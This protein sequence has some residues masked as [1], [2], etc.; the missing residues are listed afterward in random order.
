MPHSPHTFHFT[1]PTCYITLPLQI[2]L[3]PCSH[4]LL[5]KSG[6][7]AVAAGPGFRPVQ[8]ATMTSGV[9]VLDAEDLEILFPVGEFLLKRRRAEAGLDPADGSVIQPMGMLHVVQVFIAGDRATP[10]FPPP[11]RTKK[12]LL[13]LRPHSGLDEI[14]H[15]KKLFHRCS[16]LV[17]EKRCGFVEKPSPTRWLRLATQQAR[18]DAQ[19]PSRLAAQRAMAAAAPAVPKG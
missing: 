13:L 11:Y 7:I 8:I 4:L 9:G 10:Q 5:E 17:M 16:D 2:P 14:S 6:A 12:R 3:S 1:L 18:D 15:V 19:P